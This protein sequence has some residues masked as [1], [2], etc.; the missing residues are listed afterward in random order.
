MGERTVPIQ[1]LPSEASRPGLSGQVGKCTGCVNK[2]SW[3]VNF[4][5]TDP[6]ARCISIAE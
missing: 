3:M 5:K 4:V 6:S 2:L 1:R